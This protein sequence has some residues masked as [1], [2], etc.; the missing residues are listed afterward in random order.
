MRM[1]WAM[2]AA[3]GLAFA[4]F[5]SHSSAA[6][7]RVSDLQ[8]LQR[9]CAGDANPGDVIELQ[10]GTYYLESS[11]IAVLRS[12]EPGN[13][14]TIRGAVKDGRPPVIDGSRTNVKRGIFRTEEQTHDVIFEDLELCN[15]WGSRFPDRE[16]Y[17]HNAGAIYFQGTNLTARRVHSHHN[18]DGWFAT[19]S[20]DN[21]LIEDCE[22]DHNGTLFEGRH[23]ATHNFYF[24]ANHQT[25]RNCYIHHS[26][27]AQ[28]FK[29]R[30]FNTVF[31]YNW[32][33]EDAGYSVEVASG[34][35]G[36]TLWIG[37]VIIKRTSRGRPQRRLLG[38]GDGTGVAA[39]TLTMVNNTFISSFEDDLFLFTEASSTCDVVL[40]NNVFAGPSRRF[41]EQ[42]GK[43]SITGQN[44]WF[45]TGTAVPAGLSNS[46][47]GDDPG[48]VNL[49]NHDFHLRANS[50]LVDAGMDAP[51]WLDA[52]GQ[53]APAVPECEP[54]K[55][56]TRRA[57]RPRSGRLDIGAFEYAPDRRFPDG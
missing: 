49:K 1:T 7:H 16:T 13:P 19:H 38:V 32:V 4:I 30:G 28:N 24:C 11:H 47:F 45:P 46:L 51:Q 10:P 52:S 33:E 53:P 9:L 22:I 20:A 40:I 8:T 37:N 26:G 56:T 41:L 54:T 42:N 2:L 29:S 34:N 55:E 12:G 27:E 25:V 50:P 35:E 17:S 18:E 48:F 21:I 5:A 3:T 36:N 39:G 57:E 43:G 23:N 44:N 6:T 31:A 14:I 15:A